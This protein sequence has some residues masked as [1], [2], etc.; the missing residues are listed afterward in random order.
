MENIIYSMYIDTRKIVNVKHLNTK[1]EREYYINIQF[2]N[3]YRTN[4]V[5]VAYCKMYQIFYTF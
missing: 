2:Y 3:M 1:R 4:Y 5:W